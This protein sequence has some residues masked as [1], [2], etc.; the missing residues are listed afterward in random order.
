MKDFIQKTKKKL[1][2][3]IIVLLVVL[4]V[5]VLISVFSVEDSSKFSARLEKNVIKSGESTFLVLSAYNSGS[6][7]IDAEFLVESDDS[8][9]F[10][11]S[12]PDESLLVFTLLP[13]ESITRRLNVSATTNAIRTDYELVAKMVSSDNVSSSKKVVVSVKK[14]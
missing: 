1:I 12:Y 8:L 4:I 9:S 3:A 13:G 10:N 2:F 14:N 11:V 7:V 6:S 5:Y